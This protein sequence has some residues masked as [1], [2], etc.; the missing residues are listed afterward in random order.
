MQMNKLLKLGIRA[1]KKYTVPWKSAIGGHI[2]HRPKESL[3]E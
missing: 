3:F 2:F 1:E